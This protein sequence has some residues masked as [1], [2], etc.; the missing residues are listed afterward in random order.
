MALLALLLPL[1]H[2]LVPASEPLF[3]PCNSSFTFQ[4]APQWGAYPAGSGGML[5]ATDTPPFFSLG[6]TQHSTGYTQPFNLALF[7]GSTLHERYTPPYASQTAFSSS[8]MLHL[9]VLAPPVNS[10]TGLIDDVDY[11][12]ILAAALAVDED[13]NSNSSTYTKLAGGFIDRLG[14]TVL[15]AYDGSVLYNFAAATTEC[16]VSLRVNASTTAGLNMLVFSFSARDSSNV[17]ATAGTPATAQLAFDFDP[18]RV[19]SSGPALLTFAVDLGMSALYMLDGAA[20]AHASCA[21]QSTHYYG[22]YYVRWTPRVTFHDGVAAVQKGSSCCTLAS[23]AVFSLLDAATLCST[24]A[25]LHGALL[26]PDVLPIYPWEKFSYQSQVNASDSGIVYLQP[27]V[28]HVFTLRNALDGGLLVVSRF[29]LVDHS[30]TNTALLSAMPFY[31]V[32]TEVLD[33]NPDLLAPASFGAVCAAFTST[34]L[35]MP[36]SIVIDIATQQ[37]NLAS[38]MWQTPC[39]DFSCLQHEYDRGTCIVQAVAHTLLEGDC[40]LDGAFIAQQPVPIP[41]AAPGR[42]A[43][44]SAMAA[45]GFYSRTAEPPNSLVQG[46]LLIG[47]DFCSTV[48]RDCTGQFAGAAA[49]DLCSFCAGDNRACCSSAGT[50]N[51]VECVC[52]LGR[53]SATC[54]FATDT[55]GVCAGDG[56]TCCNDAGV[57][58]GGTCACEWGWTGSTCTHMDCSVGVN[59]LPENG[60][61]VCLPTHCSV[62]NGGATYGVLNCTEIVQPCGACGSSLTCCAGHGLIDVLVNASL[63]NCTC[64]PGWCDAHC[65]TPIDLCGVCGGNNRSC[66]GGHGL[67]ELSG[68]CMCDGDTCGVNCS[69]LEDRCG[70]CIYR[71]LPL[72]APEQRLAQT[73]DD[74]LFLVLPPNPLALNQTAM[75]CVSES[76]RV[77]LPSE[78]I[79]VATV[80]LNP[81]HDSVYGA[82]QRW[83]DGSA[84]IIVHTPG[85]SRWEVLNASAPDGYRLNYRTTYEGRFAAFPVTTSAGTQY[86]MD[87][88]EL[89]LEAQSTTAAWSVDHHGPLNGSALVR[90]AFGTAGVN[91]TLT[92]RLLE[93]RTITPN[94]YDQA[95][96][97]D[98]TPL[99]PQDWLYYLNGTTLLAWFKQFPGIVLP[100]TVFHAD[101]LDAKTPAYVR[102]LAFSLSVFVLSALLLGILLCAMAGRRFMP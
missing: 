16:N 59:V 3:E 74:L 8:I 88:W 102:W 83:D 38:A 90:A 97:P 22:Q 23:R 26:S 61:C 54:M 7:G 71:Y 72:S 43:L 45:C 58:D 95:V 93:T 98:S 27:T 77:A 50:F 92:V 94:F 86:Y 51:G 99:G 60:T 35:A 10:T 25:L 17:I 42:V 64:L 67:M 5:C 85:G 84:Q 44:V 29:L 69:L 96:V 20:V 89:R 13:T 40:S 65:S 19:H 52:D 79:N 87:V 101:L 4:S 33:A 68:R 15:V 37:S 32:G 78:E 39:F 62:A 18:L 6:N 75:P 2:A 70:D 24:I 48:E 73:Y 49:Y 46:A 57:F 30:S 36:Y 53:C 12:M 91:A 31:S 56:R 21:A 55:C 80:T 82:V 14:H 41:L 100:N 81:A 47:P 34:L 28:E 66:C 1:A 11:G 76:L 9:A 63:Y